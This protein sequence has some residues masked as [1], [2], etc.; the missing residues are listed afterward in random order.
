MKGFC[1]SV[2]YRAT[3]AVTVYTFETLHTIQEIRKS[4]DDDHIFVAPDRDITLK[5]F[6][7]RQRPPTC[8]FLQFPYSNW[9]LTSG[10]G[11]EVTSRVYFWYIIEPSEICGDH[12]SLGV[13]VSMSKQIRNNISC[14]FVLGQISKATQ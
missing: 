12:T 13:D 5:L 11:I 7:S 4:T 3:G 6:V 1:E 8:V 2:T 9:H 10:N 14:D